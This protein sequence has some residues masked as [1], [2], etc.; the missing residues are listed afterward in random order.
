M[1][2]KTP[3]KQETKQK[4]SEAKKES[5]PW[6]RRFG[7]F[8]YMSQGFV[9]ILIGVLAFMTAI[10]VGGDT[11]DTNGAL[12]SLAGIPF[13]EVVLWLV[14]IGLIGYVVWML[15][16]AFIDTGNFGHGIKGLL[17]RG[18]FIGSAL[19]YASLAFNAGKF[20]THA[21]GSGGSDEQTYSQLLLSQPFG[22]W[23]IG[24]VG[25][26]IIGYAFFEAYKAIKELFMKEFKAGEM[27]KHELNIARTSGKIGL[28]ARAFV[29]AVVGFF[30][31]QTAI[32]ADADETEGIDGALFELSQQ[33][34]GQWILGIVALG[35]IL[36]GVYG[37]IY[38]RYVHMNFGKHK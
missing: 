24:A 21:G 4:A 11:E 27:N 29:F 1:A 25:A 12:Q 16:R 2:K 23:M 14:A 20:A 6:I 35:L 28:L 8:G 18:G 17:I 9:Y 7:R 36:F 3:S 10:G 15:I 34:F 5:K 26:G 37:I 38:G 30:L 32:S 13:G 19:I 33:P 31:I 22:Q